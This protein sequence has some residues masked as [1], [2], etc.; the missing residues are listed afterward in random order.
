MTALQSPLA[1]LGRILLAFLFVPAGFGKIAGFSGSVGYATAMGLPLPTLGSW[2]R[3]CA[4]R[5]RKNCPSLPPRS[6]VRPAP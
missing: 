1:L 4:A 5:H 6:C 2:P 3:G